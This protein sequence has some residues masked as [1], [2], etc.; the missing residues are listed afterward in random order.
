LKATF[1]FL[2]ILFPLFVFSQDETADEKRTLILTIIILLIIIFA[3]LAY[4][5][6][7]YLKKNNSK[8]FSRF[9]KKV[10]LEV[11]LDKDKVLRPNFLT[12]TITNIGKNEADINAPVLEFR[13]IWSKRKF[14]LNGISG[15]QIYPL[16]LDPG[17]KHRLRIE[18]STFHQYD[19]SIKSYYWARIFVS[20]VDGR[21]WKS[22]RVKLRKS[23]VTWICK[24]PKIFRSAK[25][26]LSGL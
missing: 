12:M 20:D 15:S 26:K 19:R 17:A 6:N 21:R 5:L 18:T 23:L 16:F 11:L 14:K 10:N 3:M 24:A 8:G 9:F 4:E 7:R 1:L 2:S 22:N 25:R 13:K